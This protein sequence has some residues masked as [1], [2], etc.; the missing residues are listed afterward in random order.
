MD[1]LTLDTKFDDKLTELLQQ[2]VGVTDQLAAAEG[3]VDTG[4]VLPAAQTRRRRPHQRRQHATRGIPGCGAQRTRSGVDASGLKAQALQALEKC[5]EQATKNSQLSELL[6]KASGTDDP[7]NMLLNELRS[8]D[9]SFAESRGFQ[10]RLCAAIA[11]QDRDDMTQK[12]KRS[13]QVRLVSGLQQWVALPFAL[14]ASG[15]A[16]SAADRRLPAPANALRVQ[17]AQ[18]VRQGPGSAAQDQRVPQAPD[19]GVF[20]RVV[21]ASARRHCCQRA[22]PHRRLP[23]EEASRTANPHR[24]AVCRRRRAHPQPDLRQQHLQDTVR[25]DEEAAQDKLKKYEALSKKDGFDFLS[26]GEEDTGAMDPVQGFRQAAG[27]HV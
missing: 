12:L 15:E 13:Q 26:L 5:I 7:I 22:H 11:K 18:P 10:K 19:G 21:R 17:P 4:A 2:R 24:G 23:V 25:S 1:S 14:P 6:L 9:G 27:A 16:R 3:A 8:K 20:H